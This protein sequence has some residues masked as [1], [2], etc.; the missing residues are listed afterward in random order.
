MDFQLFSGHPVYPGCK[1]YILRVKLYSL[2]CLKTQQILI[3]RISYSL[4]Y[5]SSR[6][7]HFV[8]KH[9]NEGHSDMNK[10]F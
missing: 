10:R 8:V 9:E 1:N 2:H 3:Q 4:E 7:P 6:L 5:L